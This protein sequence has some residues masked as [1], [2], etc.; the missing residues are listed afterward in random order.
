MK[1]INE[2]VILAGGLGTR[3]RGVI[4][5]I[6]KPMAPI[7]DKPFLDYLFRYLKKYNIERVVLSVGYKFE[8]IKDY[9]G[10]NYL[11]IDIIYVVESTPL[12]T[13]GGIAL[14]IQEI[15]NESCFLLNGDTIFNVDL[16]LLE[17]TFH[18]LESD[19]SLS[20]KLS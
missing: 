20:L 4:S 12:G 3:L 14:A 10:E 16:S 17:T 11:G 1:K 18:S 2:A 13:G 8:T 9:F 7:N 19:L 5:E 6:P 15:Q